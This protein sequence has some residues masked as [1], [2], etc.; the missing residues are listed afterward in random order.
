VQFTETYPTVFV[1]KQTCAHRHTHVVVNVWQKQTHK[2]TQS[3]RSVKNTF[4]S[5]DIQHPKRL[6]LQYHGVW[7]W[8]NFLLLKCLNEMLRM[9]LTKKV[10]QRNIRRRKEVK[11]KRLVECK[12]TSTPQTFSISARSGRLYQLKTSSIFAQPENESRLHCLQLFT[13]LTELLPHPWL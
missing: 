2:D 13:V 12:I 6:G 1:H 4:S 11:I 7:C 3:K 8:R 5:A 10:P 9:F